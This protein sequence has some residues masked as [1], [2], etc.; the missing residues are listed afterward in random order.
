MLRRTFL[1]LLGLSPFA[2]TACKTKEPIR[3]PADGLVKVDLNDIVWAGAQGEPLTAT[4]VIAGD[5][6]ETWV[7]FDGKWF[8]MDKEMVYA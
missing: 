8:K 2:V 7:L 5:G 4:A 1:G 3:T 6:D